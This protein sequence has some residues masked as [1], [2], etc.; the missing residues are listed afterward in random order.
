MTLESLLVAR[1]AGLWTLWKTLRVSHSAHRPD[2]DE[3]EFS[4]TTQADAT[5][6][7]HVELANGAKRWV[8]LHWYE[9]HGIGRVEMKIKRYLE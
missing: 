8:E 4:Y 5:G 7:G 2:D 1:G 9:A 3:E 6:A